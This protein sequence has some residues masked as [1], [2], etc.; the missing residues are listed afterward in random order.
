M[1]VYL[2]LPLTILSILGSLFVFVIVA[3]QEYPY[4]VKEGVGLFFVATMPLVVVKVKV[5][6]SSNRLASLSRC[7]EKM[8]WLS[9][10]ILVIHFSQWPLEYTEELSPDVKARVLDV[11]NLAM[12]ISALKYMFGI[13]FASFAAQRDI[14]SFWFVLLLLALIWNF[15]QEE[16]GTTTQEFW[17]ATLIDCGNFLEIFMFMVPIFVLPWNDDVP[18][19]GMRISRRQL[20]WECG[21][22]KRM[23]NQAMA[24]MVSFLPSVFV[25]DLVFPWMDELQNGVWPILLG[26]ALHC[27]MIVDFCAYFL[28]QSFSPD[29]I[30]EFEMA[31]TKGSLDSLDASDERL[32]DTYTLQP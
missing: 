9:V 23:Q 29:A 7:A 20:E 18:S 5:W 26:R 21:S 14:L 1:G 27:A 25:E 6:G 13:S 28:L 15:H 22:V 19:D 31:E 11:G 17:M 8:I 3:P 32:L 16:T 10:C 4:W 24:L 2:V 12:R 30:S